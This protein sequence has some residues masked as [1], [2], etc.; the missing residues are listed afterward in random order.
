MHAEAINGTEKR[1]FPRAEWS[2]EETHKIK[3]AIYILS[4]GG[5]GKTSS[6][7]LKVAMRALG[8][9]PTAGPIP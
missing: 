9:E 8:F 2:G 7:E 6:N 1:D 4:V 5:S 3:D